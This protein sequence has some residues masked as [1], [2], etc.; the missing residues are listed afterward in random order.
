MKMEIPVAAPAAGCLAELYVK[1]G[2]A[3]K[4]GEMIALLDLA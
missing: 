3:V 1:E 4:E 2:D